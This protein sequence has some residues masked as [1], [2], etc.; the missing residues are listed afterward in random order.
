MGYINEHIIRAVPKSDLPGVHERVGD[1]APGLVA[2]GRAEDERT[3]RGHAADPRH[4]RVG[5][6][7]EHRIDDEHADDRG[8]HE[9][10]E[11]RR[12]LAVE[13]LDVLLLVGDALRHNNARHVTRDVRHDTP[14]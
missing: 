6:R 7:E 10:D 11:E 12:R 13:V 8:R 1:E 9:G 5:L 4:G 2:P 14:R 3:V